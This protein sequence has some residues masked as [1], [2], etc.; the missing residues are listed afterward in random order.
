MEIKRDTL[1]TITEGDILQ[2]EEV[3]LAMAKDFA[4][5]SG[6]DFEGTILPALKDFSFW[7]VDYLKDSRW[8]L[9]LMDAYRCLLDVHRTT[10]IMGGIRETIKS[11]KS[12]G[13]ENI[14]AID[15]GTG[16]GIFAIYLAVLGCKRVYALE[17]NQETAE[18]ATRFIHLYGFSDKIEVIVGD[19][20][21]IDIPVLRQEPAQ[22]LVSENLSG[23]LFSE[24]QYQMIEHLS[25]FSLLSTD[26]YREDLEHIE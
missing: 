15:A 5:L 7:E 23:G 25:E 24:P 1:K 14:I 4:E 9:S 17:L 2:G 11:L 6:V 3:I 21:S 26:G 19:A 10:Q 20:T 22:I 13:E 8:G 12:E 16:T 18:L